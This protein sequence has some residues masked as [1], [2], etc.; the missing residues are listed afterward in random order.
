MSVWNIIASVF[1]FVGA[2]FVIVASIGVVRFPD[3]FTR[4]HAAGKCDTLGLG[5]VLLGL[6][7][8][9]PAV[10]NTAKLLLI[11]VFIALANPTATHAIAR[12]AYRLGLRPLL[13]DKWKE[14]KP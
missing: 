2:F 5:L 4:I 12:A 1:L 9:E 8:Y 11:A 3:F 13:G 7:V 10:L 6:A 14:E